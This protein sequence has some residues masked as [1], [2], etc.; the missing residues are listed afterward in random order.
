MIM[1][2]VDDLKLTS[3]A[4]FDS[5]NYELLGVRDLT[6]VENALQRFKPTVPIHVA[7]L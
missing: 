2:Y 4:L 6:G 3:Q 5:L 1:K 7:A